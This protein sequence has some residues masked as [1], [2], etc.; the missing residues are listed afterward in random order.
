MRLFSRAFATITLGVALAVSLAGCA[1]TGVGKLVGA[2]QGYTVQP[3]DM[4]IADNTFDVISRTGE[5]YIRACTAGLPL[6]VNNAVVPDIITAVRSGRDARNNLKAFVRA[7]PGQL[8]PSGVY[9]AVISANATLQQI[10]TR[11]GIKSSS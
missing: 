8:G 2:V 3:K 11:Y 10:F 9:D 1:D 4:I 5:A 6:C 7:H